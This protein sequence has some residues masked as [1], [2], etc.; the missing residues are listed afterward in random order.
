MKITPFS[1]LRPLTEPT[2]HTT[3][4]A[5][6]CGSG[7]LTSEKT[8]LPESQSAARR[9]RIIQQRRQDRHSPY[10]RPPHALR[11]HEL[12]TTKSDLR[13][14]SIGDQRANRDKTQLGSNQRWDKRQRVEEERT[15]DLRPRKWAKGSPDEE[16]GER[17]NAA[18]H[19]RFNGQ[20][21]SNQGSYPKAEDPHSPVE[22][23]ILRPDNH[24]ITACLA[25]VANASALTAEEISLLNRIRKF[26]H[27]NDM[28]KMMALLQ[29]PVEDF[30]SEPDLFSRYVH[31]LSALLNDN[32]T[33]LQS[34]DKY[35]LT[36]QRFTETALAFAATN[37]TTED[38]GQGVEYLARL[39]HLSN[40]WVQTKPNQGA[41]I[42]AIADALA[43]HQQHN[44][45]SGLLQWL[46]KG[47]PNAERD[48]GLLIN[49]MSKWPRD[50]ACL[51]GLNT[52]AA[53][54]ILDKHA[55]SNYSNKTLAI[56]ANGISKI[57][58]SETTQQAMK[59]IATVIQTRPQHLI[60]NPK[61]TPQDMANL[62]SGLSKFQDSKTCQN[63]I[64]DL[65]Y[66][67]KSW[68]RQLAQ[69]WQ[70]NQQGISSIINA[71]GKF[72]TQKNCQ[73][74]AAICAQALIQRRQTHKESFVEPQDLMRNINGLSKFSDDKTCRRAVVML[75]ERIIDCQPNEQKR[76]HTCSA[77]E[78][79]GVINGLGK[80]QDSKTCEQ[81]QRL[82]AG[83]LL[84]RDGNTSELA[85]FTALHLSLMV[86]GFG[87][88]AHNDKIA[89]T[90][91][92]LTQLLLIRQEQLQ[93]K[94]VF[95]AQNL[96]TLINGF[97]KFPQGKETR[98]ALITLAEAVVA[99]RHELQQAHA[100][101]F[102]DL[103]SMLNG[104]SKLPDHPQCRH[105]VA[106]ITE[107]RLAVLPEPSVQKP[108][109]LQEFCSIINALSKFAT[110]TSA[111]Q[112]VIKIVATLQQQTG[113]NFREFDP[114]ALSNII[115]GL[116]K[117]SCFP[118]CEQMVS[119]LAKELLLR[120]QDL[121]D[122]Q[123]F[124]AQHLANICNGLSHFNE[125]KNCQDASEMLANVLL[126]R[127]RE[128]HDQHLFLPL[129]LSILINGLSRFNDNA[130]CREMVEHIAQRVAEDP[131]LN[132]Q[133]D[134]NNLA[135]AMNGFS[136]F[137][138]SEICHQALAELA[139]EVITRKQQ[140]NNKDTASMR[141]FSTLINALSKYP[142]DK[143]CRYASAV[144][145]TEIR[146]RKQ[147]LRNPQL[148]TPA[149]IA[150]TLN[151]LTKFPDEQSCK[152]ASHEIIS[153]LA[154][155]RHELQ[156]R[157]EFRPQDLANVLNALSKNNGEKQNQQLAE[158]II[159]LLGSTGHA[160]NEF[161]LPALSVLA[162]GMARFSLALND[163]LNEE[164]SQQNP[165]VQLI[166]ARLRELTSHLNSRPE[167]L[168][169]SGARQIGI[170][171]K[172]LASLALKDCLRLIGRQ[173]LNRLTQIQSETQF[174]HDD[175]ETLSSVMAGLRPLLCS[176]EL[177]KFHRDTLR[178][179]ESMQPDVARKIKD[180]QTHHTEHAIASPS[181]ANTV[182]EAHTTRRPGLT[183]FLILK[184]YQVVVGMWK[185]R[186]V[187]QRSDWNDK[188]QT[189]QNIWA[190]RNAMKAWL[191]QT[192]EQVKGVIE[193][194]LDESAW[195]LIAQI[196][197]DENIL[198][199]L[200]LKLRK[201]Y[202]RIA[203]THPPT[204]INV[205]TVRQQLRQLTDVQDMMH[206]EFGA[207]K[208]DVIDMN[209]KSLNIDAPSPT[210]NYSFFTR[211]T[212]GILPLQEVQLPGKVSAF[213][214]SRIIKSQGDLL[215]MDMFGG[216]HI[217]PT[218]K[219]VHEL[220][221]S[222]SNTEAKRY[223]RLP[224]L[225]VADTLADAPLMKHVISKL[226]PQR[227]DWFR[228]QRALLEIVPRENVI[229]GPIK[230]S[231]IPDNMD[232]AQRVFPIRTADNRPIML[233]PHDGCGFIRASLAQKI[234]AIK[235]AMQ[236]HATAPSLRDQ[237]QQHL[238][239]KPRMSPLPPQAT[240]HFPR[241][242]AA[243]DEARQHLLQSL[244]QDTDYQ[245]NV[246]LK[247]QKLYEILVSANLFG[248]QGTAVPS[249]D[250]KL[251]LPYQSDKNFTLGR[252]PLLLGK[253]PYDKAN[254]M[255]IAP[256]RVGS[257]DNQDA[258]AQFLNETFAFQYSYTAWDESATSNKENSQAEAPMLHGKGVTI[259]I[260]DTMWPDN[261][262]AQWVWSTE[263]MKIHSDWVKGRQR[264]KLPP[265]METL[266]CLRVK[267]IFPPGSLIAVPI[268]E[269]KKRDA[270]CDGDK[271]FVYAGLPAMAAA[272]TRHLTDR[273]QQA[274]KAGSF[275][276]PKTA[277][278]AFDTENRYHAG[279]AA[280]ILSTLRGNELLGKMSLMQFQFSAQDTSM[281]QR[282][283][284][285]ALFGTYEGTEQTLRRALRQRLNQQQSSTETT[286]PQRALNVSRHQQSLQ[287][288]PI[289]QDPVMTDHELLYRAEMGLKYARH[290]L[291]KQVA[292]ILLSQLNHLI[293]QGNTL[294]APVETAPPPLTL[295]T[296]LTTQFP[297][298]AQALDD[299][300]T[301][302]A[303][304]QAIVEHYPKALLPHTG[305]T[306]PAERQHEVSSLGDGQPGYIVSQ[307]VVSLSNLLTMGVK[308]GTDAPKAVTQ[309][310]LFLKVADRLDSALH[311]EH[312]R[313][314]I[315]P[316]TKSGVV[317]ELREGRIH[318]DAN[319]NRLQDNPTLSAGLMEMAIETLLEE[320][321]LQRQP[322]AGIIS[323]HNQQQLPDLAQ[324]L[325]Q[326]ARQA[327][328]HMT[329][330]LSRC[331]AG[332]GELLGQQHRLKSLVSLQEKLEKI[333]LRDR[334][335]ASQAASSIDDALRY[336]VILD[337]LHFTAAYSHI[338]DALD[339]QG[340]VRTR[341]HNGFT[342][343]Q[344]TFKGINV[345]FALP[346]QQESL[347]RLEI[348][349]HTA[350][351]FA[352]K[353]QYHDSYKALFNMSRA[354]ASA[355][356]RHASTQPIKNIFKH[357][358]TPPDCEH[359]EDW[360]FDPTLLM[361]AASASPD[362]SPQVQQLLQHARVIE[363]QITP[364]LEQLNLSISKAHSGLK[365]EKS[366][367]QKIIRLATLN[368]LTEQQ[369]MYQIRD[370]VRWVIIVPP[371]DFGHEATRT[372]EG[373]AKH[374]IKLMRVN[375][376][377][378]NT[379]RSYAGLNMNF[380]TPQGADF[381][382]Q[383]HT[384]QSLSN[385][386]NTHDLYRH[387]QQDEV[388]L[389]H[390][391]D[392]KQRA[393]LQH[394]NQQRYKTLQQAANQ[395][396]TPTGVEM[397]LPCNHYD[398]E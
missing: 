126:Q 158:E 182:T 252:G 282:M 355:E 117:F 349:F 87:K 344:Q 300:T 348:Q 211:L 94:Q 225:R 251:H 162:N 253:A 240:H 310:D 358:P 337:P 59:K 181:D 234:P 286:A 385:K 311:S 236:A 184:T 115:N 138:E 260:P 217:K 299:A 288:T 54:L 316:Y 359:I 75:A 209:G 68:D 293:Q 256:E 118:E 259:V 380:R 376:G 205:D 50:P 232:A 191:S 360:K 192:T 215:R 180:Y 352:L 163:N 91:S 334:V 102:W 95:S 33:Y 113:S 63:A 70:F 20:G 141:C 272:I 169:Q 301:A 292:A 190:R 254:L 250:D 373:L 228:M 57:T 223:G 17:D 277:H 187:L 168:A 151:G 183:F 42:A 125:D 396:M 47:T 143:V 303:R 172:A 214:L 369:A 365:K 383:F 233:R 382:L 14:S 6:T 136:K 305:T 264:D 353:E 386:N 77:D 323:Q 297:S 11:H 103:A 201:D 46:N 193:H 97:G 398:N 165:Q 43:A 161:T 147:D 111:Q 235:Q 78:L 52:L 96:S 170:I 133:F 10:S 74:A 71:L 306:L 148:F 31:A 390:T 237:Q 319:L 58:H 129:H 150:N 1:P 140:L 392:P 224:A 199:S 197:A 79:S 304:L 26:I 32:Q 345:K 142:Q 357:V 287:Q 364:L 171:F 55:L 342:S 12:Q 198:D 326:Q 231:L 327:E 127:Q 368:Q 371:Q 41:G 393:H 338:L 15:A 119:Q 134:L 378:L 377:F 76:L 216:S 178:L 222:G 226:N 343:S 279:R 296:E 290:P 395:V 188:G 278:T 302:R 210:L 330:I 208:L 207:A 331:I 2:Q 83:I 3:T 104:F 8:E 107:R 372:I 270:D 274:G 157:G 44:T 34:H 298:L 23:D 248:I 325:Y 389:A 154:E 244:R 381:E 195:N 271:V 66:A 105:A 85:A 261:N 99:R 285:R 88:F 309:T 49:A 324:Q 89:E 132:K 266:G 124:S 30:I 203:L 86:N 156:K 53:I 72:H 101:S 27:P 268:N 29:R 120:P 257:Q 341:V 249:A 108:M 28:T 202:Q 281:Q 242:Q 335:S 177:K 152:Q 312:E 21:R 196:E 200:D 328:P 40:R 212:G 354:G 346:R 122:K 239:A 185:H 13:Q 164:E 174:R 139:Y 4:S 367:Q 175:L 145:A 146:E 80:F 109:K 347:I 69:P 160:Y 73:K 374:G 366:L 39:S 179:L 213:M 267:E 384:K 159:K 100:F 245:N 110:Q 92:S 362:K 62:F 38:M 206:N 333:I 322:P 317:R 24:Q 114:I 246:P 25:R 128:L 273:E 336:S 144:I 36:V 294:K 269:L 64:E 7:P 19:R 238:L 106:E 363:K 37:K 320:G 56:I 275:K 291:A 22:T 166:H 131:S 176:P 258:T 153:A 18:Q 339:R 332:Q 84:S 356:Q 387:W 189:Q 130:S 16:I 61:I 229:E 51:G 81:A 35:A 194:D 230:L 340:L 318:V 314:R 255:A 391:T 241:D 204:P 45:L 149:Y 93:D 220:I 315:V 135:I 350:Q 394:H 98:I 67:L 295:N 9:S 5:D 65:A 137:P 307:P 218:K 321:K 284:I 116:G 289:P 167:R 263:D 90:A 173:G 186:H 313:K 60:P 397:I 329:A 219:R 370:T 262:D 265:L 221:A 155:R 276:P 123:Q 283:A 82:M 48:L 375:N 379:D 243:I 247:P 388:R 361:Q 308:A 280:E 112:A 121:C 227:E 351:T